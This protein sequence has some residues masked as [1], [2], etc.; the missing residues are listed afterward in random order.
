MGLFVTA[1]GAR[2]CLKAAGASHPDIL[3]N[4]NTSTV[5]ETC[6]KNWPPDRNANPVAAVTDSP[7][8]APCNR[9]LGVWLRG[10]RA[11]D[12]GLRV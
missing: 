10:V 2:I 9:N 11:Y 1:K 7:G 3:R 4:G 5:T 8:A 6:T 12:A